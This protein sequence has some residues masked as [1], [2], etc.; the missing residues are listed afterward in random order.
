MR[1]MSVLYWRPVVYWSA[2]A[3]RN[4]KDPGSIPGRVEK[5]W[6][7]FLYA[8]CLCLPSSDWEPGC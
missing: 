2:F 6:A 4:R 3:I 8:N 1:H 5:L 7:S